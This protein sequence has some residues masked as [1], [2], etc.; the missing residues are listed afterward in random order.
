MS[1]KC[2][3][4]WSDHEPDVGCTFCNTC[5]RSGSC[6][7]DEGDRDECICGAG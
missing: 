5:G 2:G 6:D 3:H 1:C 7:C 4:S